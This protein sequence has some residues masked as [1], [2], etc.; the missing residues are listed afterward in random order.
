[1]VLSTLALLAAMA[2]LLWSF[3]DPRAE[4]LLGPGRTSL[5]PPVVGGPPSREVQD[6]LSRLREEVKALR[7]ELVQAGTRRDAGRLT[8]QVDGELTKADP[9]DRVRT[10]SFAR[11]FHVRFEQGRTYQIDLLGVN[12]L[13][14]YLRLDE[15]EDRE[16]TSDD[17][18]GGA[19]NARIRFEC[20]RTGVY[21]VVATTC[22][23]DA[24]GRFLLL[25]REQ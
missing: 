23:G 14:T 17:D 8:L 4:A 6:G 10:T 22:H 13:D 12:G 21:R 2:F 24:T 9:R 7:T 5:R 11:V 18:G 16:V 25:I 19:R 3:L 15:V 20:S 1:M